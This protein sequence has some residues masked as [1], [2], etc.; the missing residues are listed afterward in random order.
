MAAGNLVDSV[1]TLWNSLLLRRF[2]FRMA[3]MAEASAKRVTGDTPQGTKHDITRP[4]TLSPGVAWQ[5]ER[6]QIVGRDAHATT[7][8]GNMGYDQTTV[9]GEP[10]RTLVLL[11]LSFSTRKH[12]SLASRTI[13][14]N[15]SEEQCPQS[16]PQYLS[17]LSRAISRFTTCT[18]EPPVT[19]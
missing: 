12:M 16:H 17:G 18:D 19:P 6:G 4:W 15:F 5:K 2:V 11:L 7:P 13:L 3:D 14:S 9:A 10:R 8:K 1:K